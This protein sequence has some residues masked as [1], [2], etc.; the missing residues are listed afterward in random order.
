MILTVALPFTCAEGTLIG[1]VGEDLEVVVRVFG[2]PKQPDVVEQA[3]G[4]GFVRSG[5]AGFAGNVGSQ[6]GDELAVQAVVAVGAHACPALRLL[7]DVPQ[8]PR[9]Q[10]SGFSVLY[11]L[12]NGFQ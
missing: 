7:H 9:L 5:I 12:R 11:S 2:Q 10:E 4:I 6:F 1:S 3:R 8:G